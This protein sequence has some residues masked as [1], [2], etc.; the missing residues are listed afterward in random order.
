MGIDREFCT[1]TN[2][3]FIPILFSYKKDDICKFWILC[4]SIID[5]IAEINVLETFN[6]AYYSDHGI[7]D[8]V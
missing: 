8:Q 6:L 3:D 1:L 5:M 2:L 4:Q 7:S